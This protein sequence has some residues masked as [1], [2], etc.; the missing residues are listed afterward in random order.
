MKIP[1]NFKLMKWNFFL[2]NFNYRVQC[3]IQNL[4]LPEYFL[5]F[6]HNTEHLI[7][8]SLCPAL[9]FVWL[10]HYF[11][12]L[13]SLLNTKKLYQERKV[14][15][16]KLHCRV[17]EKCLVHHTLRVKNHFNLFVCKYNNTT[18]YYYSMRKSENKFGN[19]QPFH[20]GHTFK[21]YLGRINLSIRP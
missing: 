10:T 14:A 19:I 21:K 5:S 12:R 18:G 6:F 3:T 1:K 2:S 16:H 20:G 11:W 9:N 15:I 8:N 17:R 7:Y 13:S 4:E